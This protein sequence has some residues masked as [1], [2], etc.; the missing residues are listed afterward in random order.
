MSTS[1]IHLAELLALGG[2]PELRR[3]A[4]RCAVAV[5][6]RNERIQAMRGLRVELELLYG[7]GQESDEGFHAGPCTLRREGDQVV[8]Y[9]AATLEGAA[10]YAP[11]GEGDVT[12]PGVTTDEG[13]ATE[14]GGYP[15]E[16]EG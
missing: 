8:V 3:G 13:D 15:P 4:V 6:D 7:E 10:R 1:S 11:G 12:E 9:V 2:A 5:P 16:L 14:P